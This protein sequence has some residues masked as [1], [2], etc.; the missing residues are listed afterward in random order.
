MK[1]G[2][3]LG[4][5]QHRGNETWIKTSKMVTKESFLINFIKLSNS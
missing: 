4:I 2:G 5:V 3:I 1:K